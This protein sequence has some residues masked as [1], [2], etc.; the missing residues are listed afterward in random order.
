VLVSVTLGAVDVVLQHRL[1]LRD[2]P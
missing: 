1:F 2:M